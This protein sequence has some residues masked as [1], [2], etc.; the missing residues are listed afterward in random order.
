M[1]IADPGAS[2]IAAANSG[3]HRLLDEPE[4]AGLLR[5]TRL[6]ERIFHVPAAY[7]AMLGPGL[8]V[9]SRIGSGNQYWTQLR[10]FPL[11][12]AVGHPQ[13]FHSGTESPEGF[14]WGDLK[15]AA[16]APLRS[17]DGLELGVLVIADTRRRPDF[18]DQDR[19]TL[20]ELAT[21]LAGKMEL[22]TLACEARE[23]ELSLLEAERRFRNIANSAPVLIIYSGTDGSCSFVNKT[24]L[25]FTGRT[26]EEEIGEG[27]EEA[28]HPDHRQR[29][30]ELY[31][32]AFQRRE[33]SIIEFPMRRYDGEYRW[34]VARGTPRLQED[35]AF[36][37]YIGCFTDVTNQRAAALGLR[38]QMLCTA[39][40]AEASGAAYLILDREGRIEQAAGRTP[41]A[42]VWEGCDANA[43]SIREAFERAVQS[44]TA[45]KARTTTQ[46]WTFTPVRS[47]EG[48]LLAVT[49]TVFDQARDCS[50]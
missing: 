28:F 23:T 9:V 43:A 47:E 38:K 26:L 44:G 1:L 40:V 39:V 2:V 35:G 11:R 21:I 50:L 13:V 18:S 10:S 42:Y 5:V 31:W 22:R 30:M 49:A 25:E 15:F 46:H 14:E 45:T 24:W 8:Q 41:G 34:M 7:I 12:P 48:E 3:S 6:V 20:S 27:F 16:S 29:V 19:E 33:P 4:H 17:I 36:A 37:G 32:N